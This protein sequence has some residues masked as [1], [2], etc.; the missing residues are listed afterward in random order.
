MSGDLVGDQS[1]HDVAARYVG[2]THSLV[3]SA[4]C[5]CFQIG[6]S[7]LSVSISHWPA[8]KASAR[9]GVLTTIATLASASGTRPSRWTMMT[10]Y[11]RPAA[12]GFGLQLRQLL[13][14]HFVVGLVVE[15]DGLPAV[16]QFARRAEE[17]HDRPGLRA[18]RL[19]QQGARV[20]RLV[21]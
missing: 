14:G 17:Q 12:A 7:R 6:T 16:G 15:R 8:A 3:P 21:A 20:D 9:C 4:Q 18:R 11:Q 5:S 1:A 19:R 10:F 2:C 13:L